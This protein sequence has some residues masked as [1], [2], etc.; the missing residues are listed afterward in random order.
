[1][2]GVL[3]KTHFEQLFK[4]TEPQKKFHR[5][6]KQVRRPARTE[7]KARSHRCSPA[8]RT[9]ALSARRQFILWR[10][11]P[12]RESQTTRPVSSAP[13]GLYTD[14][15]ELM[16]LTAYFYCK[17]HFAQLFKEKGAITT[18]SRLPP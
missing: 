5:R 14:A 13:M 7:H 16:A 17:H 10:S 9:N 4:E 6:C 11:L 8:R 12:W 15:V 2:D 18:L 3:C 1:M